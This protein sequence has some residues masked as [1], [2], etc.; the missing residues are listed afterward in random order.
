MTRVCIVPL[1]SMN[2]KKK[3]DPFCGSKIPGGHKVHA[4]GPAIANHGMI[5]LIQSN[6]IY[7]SV[8]ST[9]GLDVPMCSGDAS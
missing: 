2:H 8:G 4:V 3:R 1:L 7:A 5:R 6:K 9:G